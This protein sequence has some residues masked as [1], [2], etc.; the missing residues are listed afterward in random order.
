MF[1]Y[2]REY[3]IKITKKN[4]LIIQYKKTV[5]AKNTSIIVRMHLFYKI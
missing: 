5:F 1:E 3:A 4:P 2:A